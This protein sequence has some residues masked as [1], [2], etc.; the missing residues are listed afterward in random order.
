VEPLDRRQH[1]NNVTVLVASGI[2]VHSPVGLHTINMC[3]KFMSQVL[4]YLCLITVLSEVMYF[5]RDQNN[6]LF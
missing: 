6:E 5:E 3:S 4:S 2:E 1:T